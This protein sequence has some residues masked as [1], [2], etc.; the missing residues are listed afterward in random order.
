MLLPRVT[1]Q[2]SGTLTLLHIPASLLSFLL[3]SI[4]T[5]WLTRKS[6]TE[7]QLLSA[8]PHSCCRFPGHQLILGFGILREMQK[9]SLTQEWIIIEHQRWRAPCSLIPSFRGPETLETGIEIPITNLLKDV[10]ATDRYVMEKPELPRERKH[11]TRSWMQGKIIKEEYKTCAMPIA[12][13]ETHL[14]IFLLEFS[15]WGVKHHGSLLMTRL[16]PFIEKSFF[17]YIL[18]WLWFPLPLIL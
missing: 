13:R 18:L 9:L 16:T 5:G 6:P 7:C 4:S 14:F 12:V 1:S 8:P 3:Q 17:S 2:P 10:Y 15:P 11:K